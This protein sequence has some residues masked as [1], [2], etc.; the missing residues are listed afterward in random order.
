MATFNINEFNRKMR[1]AQQKAE[2]QLKREVDRVNS[3]NKRA[4]DKYNRK[5]EAH[6]KKVVADYNRGNRSPGGVKIR[7]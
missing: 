7:E 6:N 3:A 1:E 4:V 2:Q 5:V